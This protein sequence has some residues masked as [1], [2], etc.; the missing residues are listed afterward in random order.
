[1]TQIP[2][3]KPHPFRAR[4]IDVQCRQDGTLLLRSTIPYR[5]IPETLPGLL[6][7]NARLHPDRTW[8]A[9]RRGPLGAWTHLR[10]ADAKA[11]VDAV[12]QALLNLDR[13]GRCVMV[14][15][16]NSLAHAVLAIAAMQ[17]HM[18]YAPITPAYS[19]QTRD[20]EKLQSMIDLL[21]PAVVF[22]EDGAAFAQAL[23]GVRLPSDTHLVCVE[24]PVA[25][26][27]AMPWTVWT[28]TVATEAVALAMASLSP[29]GVA[30]YLFTSGSTGL[31]KAATITHGMLSAIVAMH[32]RV[33]D[34]TALP[35]IEMLDWLPWSHVA[36]GNV[37]FA[38]VLSGA[39]TI[40]LDQGKPVPG[41]F[42][43]TLRNLREVSPTEYG[44][45]PL[46]YTMLVAALEDDAELAKHFFARVQ[47]LSYAGAK[48]P[49]SLIDRM[50]AVA[51]R[52]IGHRIPFISAFGSTETGASATIAHWDSAPPG[53]IGLPHPGVELKLFPMA[54]G[55]Y[56]VRVRSDAVIRSYFRNPEATH[57]AFDEEGF[58]CMGDAVQFVDPLHPEEG[59]VFSG[60]VAEEF[61]LQS[62]VFVRVGSLRVEA[63]EA[64][65]GML[66]DVVVT[67]A[68]EEFIGLLAWLDLAACRRKLGMPE[69]T[70]GEVLASD[71][72]RDTLCAAFRAH[73][74][75]CGGSSR[76][77][78]RILLLAEPPDL[79][80]GELTDK[81]Y[82]N[83]RLVL[84]R[85]RADVRRLH[86]TVP[87]AAVISIA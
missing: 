78:H 4:S 65:A 72:L 79:G 80:A 18:P 48:M 53:C 71:G 20:Y 1:M 12:S 60:R 28:S 70:A 7:R 33:E 21:D 66:S 74:L 6:A 56:E 10:Y 76:R 43:P 73:N 58:F 63:I 81:G 17:A 30:K 8:L 64:A 27:D 26:L 22:V 16:E 42:D 67:G 37:I 82:V 14:L 47:R 36:S 61:K 45:V 11:Q 38:R 41:R 54:D 31:P 40:W 29:D 2:S 55:R 57:S 85:R 69:A 84:Q 13:A 3:Y 49:E 25:G 24:N 35:P 9:Q 75:Q 46:G 51:I 39:G 52:A 68:D 23:K 32:E 5:P 19:L 34:R 50:Q 87:D 62:G 15:S 86:A 83:Q 59:L 44:S 77:I